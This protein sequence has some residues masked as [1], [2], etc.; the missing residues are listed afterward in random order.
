MRSNP[1]RSPYLPGLA[2]TTRWAGRGAFG[3]RPRFWKALAAG[4]VLLVSAVATI[5]VIMK[6]QGGAGDSGGGGGGEPPTPPSPSPPSLP[7]AIVDAISRSDA[8]GSTTEPSGPD[9]GYMPYVG[10]GFLGVWPRQRASRGSVTL[11]ARQPPASSAPPFTS[12][13][14]STASGRRRRATAPQFPLHSKCGPR[15]LGAR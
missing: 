15:Q 1:T 9:S 10:N 4:G 13:A 8:L 7:A 11:L 2:L 3:R 12:A 6:A 5:L 14:S